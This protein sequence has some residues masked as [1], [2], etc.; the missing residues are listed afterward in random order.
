MLATAEIA[1][2]L[3]DCGP[4][5]FE[6]VM[7]LTLD[8]ARMRLVGCAPWQ[9][10]EVVALGGLLGIQPSSLIDLLGDC[11]EEFASGGVERS[12]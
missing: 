9:P 3:I 6:R 1:Y 4:K 10:G 8:E 12:E 5:E 7:G 2:K 11:V